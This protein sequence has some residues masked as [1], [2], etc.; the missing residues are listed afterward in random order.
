MSALQRKLANVIL[1]LPRSNCLRKLLS[2][3][4]DIS[5]LHKD[6][7]GYVHVYTDGSCEGNGKDNARAG[8]GIWWADNHN[9]NRGEPATNRATNNT[10]EIEAA[11]EAI[12]LATKNG[13]IAKLKIHTD[14][15]FLI[16]CVND[17]MPGWKKKNWRTS[18]GEP[19]KNR[20][21]LEDLDEAINAAVPGEAVSQSLMLLVLLRMPRN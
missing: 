9:L 18:V 15:D 4:S 17:W 16:Q 2:L 8:Y 19:V 13:G 14:S 6:Q 10:A 12:K 7:D 1:R 11:T 20:K 21:E 3:S 5:G